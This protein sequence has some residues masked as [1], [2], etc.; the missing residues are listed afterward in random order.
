[1]NLTTILQQARQN[2]ALSIVFSLLLIVAAVALRMLT[3]IT[4]SYVTFYP[5]VILAT[6]AGGWLVGIAVMLLSTFCVVFVIAPLAPGDSVS[7]TTLWNVG[8]FWLVCLL[9][10]WLTDLLIDVLMSTREKAEKLEVLYQ[11]LAAAEQ[12]QHTLM[13]ELSHRM[14][15][16]YAVILAMA[17][18]AG[19]DSGS[20]AEFQAAF[21]D[22][23]QSMSRA[24]DLLTRQEWKAVRL[25]DLID[26]ELAAFG[27][28]GRLEVRGADLWLREH[29]VVNIGMALHELA[30]N[31]SKH[32]AWSGP[33][34]KVTV[35]WTASEGGLL[36]T[37]SETGGPPAERG[38]RRGFGSRILK[39]IVPA[40][41]QG[42]GTLDMGSE[43]LRW[44][45]LLP[46]ECL[47]TAD[48]SS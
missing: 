9:I 7:P 1:M 23:L 33:C 28:E 37:W 15:N 27:P 3:P 48:N 22:R 2:R 36:F 16:Q 21:S 47:A 32:G 14:K 41:L 20:V 19:H 40:A 34:G 39:D 10:I 43:G 38:E 30:T 31:A 45:L 18:A 17:R 5:A 44:T 8:A 26:S 6:V 24:H 4:L 46:P 42:T 25:R 12:Q 35:S 11:K 29:A 13:R